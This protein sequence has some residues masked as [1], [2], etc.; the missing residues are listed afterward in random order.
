M[1]EPRA[2][3]VVYTAR[4]RAV[5]SVRNLRSGF[6]DTPIWVRALDLRHAAELTE[7]GATAVITNN[8]E[9]GTALGSS[10][11]SGL[12]VARQSQLTYLTRAL[13]AQM[14]A[15][16]GGML[17]LCRCAAALYAPCCGGAV[18]GYHHFRGRWTD[19]KSITPL[20]RFE[21]V[22]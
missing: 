1:K 17:G 8:T 4:A 12:G 11:L 18:N 13:R 5:N 15:R 2:F 10:L 7:A 6:P 14:E 3:A 19:C 20:T 9:S 22:V 21:Y 16:C